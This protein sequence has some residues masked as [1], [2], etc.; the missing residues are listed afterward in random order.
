MKGFDKVFARGLLVGTD[1][2][3]ITDKMIVT[4]KWKV[5]KVFTLVYLFYHRSTGVWQS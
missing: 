4:T 1:M 5:D 2:P 3:R